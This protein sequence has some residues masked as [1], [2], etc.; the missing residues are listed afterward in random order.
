M[1]RELRL[2]GPWLCALATC[3]LL[4]ALAPSAWAQGKTLF[5]PETT[6]R[7]GP[8]TPATVADDEAAADDAAGSVTPVLAAMLGTVP[9]NAEIA[10]LELDTKLPP[11]L[12]LDI[13]A[14]LPG[15][16]APVTPRDVVTWN[17]NTS[18][19][20][21]L[22]DGAANGVPPNA[23]I[24]AVSYSATGQLLLSFD[25]TVALPGVTADDEDLVSWSPGPVYAMFFD[26]SANGVPTNLDLDAASRLDFTSNILLLSFDG[27]G[28][29]AGIPFDDE[30][31][32]EFD[33]GTST[34]SMYADSSLSDPGNWPRTDL[35]ALPE[36]GAGLS[37]LAGAALLAW[38][39]RRRRR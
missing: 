19:F 29:I 26:G 32:L 16:A 12:A 11:A 33:P 8:V 28:V 23:K 10:G 31:V 17:P 21:L 35:V 39:T 38:L 30:D 18:T 13:T 37:L 14:P 6:S 7:L 20:S 34:W 36:P 9:P 4:L 5:V 22:F 3:A 27:S 25:T 2:A 15:L 1:T 24:D